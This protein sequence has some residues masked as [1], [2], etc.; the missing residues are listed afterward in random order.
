MQLDEGDANRGSEH[1]TNKKDIWNREWVI[2][3]PISSAKLGSVSST[4]IGDKADFISVIDD[5]VY[6]LNF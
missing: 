5:T 3:G 1:H 4:Y 6:N 2:M